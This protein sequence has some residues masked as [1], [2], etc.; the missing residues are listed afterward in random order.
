[1][2]RSKGATSRT[3]V[4][5]PR[6]ERGTPWTVAGFG[7][8]GALPEPASHRKKKPRKELQIL[9]Q[10][11]SKITNAVRIRALA[12]PAKCGT[13][14]PS[15]APSLLSKEGWGNIFEGNEWEGFATSRHKARE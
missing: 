10:R 13:K 9:S 3:G 7:K 2:R 14:V 5:D 1:V 11:D 8:G 4:S 6:R 15:K 12:S